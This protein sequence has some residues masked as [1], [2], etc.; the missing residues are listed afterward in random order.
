MLSHF[1]RFTVLLLFLFAGSVTQAQR[2]VVSVEMGVSKTKEISGAWRY[3]QNNRHKP[4]SIL[5]ASGARHIASVYYPSIGVY[6]D[7]DTLAIE[8]KC[9]LLKMCGIDAISFCLP[10]NAIDDP[11]FIHKQKAHFRYMERYGLKAFPRYQAIDTAQMS[12][13]MDLFNTPQQ[14]YLDKRPLFSFFNADMDMNL[15]EDWRRSRAA[16]GGVFLMRRLYTD[17]IRLTPNFDGVYDWVGDGKGKKY[18]STIYPYIWHYNARQIKYAYRYDIRKARSLQDAGLVHY[19]A[20]G[21][22]PGFDDIPVN[23]WGHGPRYIERDNGRV[24]AY[25]WKRAVRNGFPMVVIPTWDDWGEGTTIAPTVEYGD[26]YLKITRKYAAAYKGVKEPEGD[27]MLPVWIYRLRKSSHNR[28]LVAATDSASSLIVQGQFRQAAQ[29]IQPWL[30]VFPVMSVRYWDRAISLSEY[31]LKP[32]VEEGRTAAATFTIRKT[33]NG[34]LRYTIAAN[35][36]WLTVSKP[37]GV[38]H[39]GGEALVQVRCGSAGLKKGIHEGLLTVS[40]PGSC[41]KTQTIK[42]QLEVK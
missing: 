11:W 12:W 20:E 40:D 39:T 26:Q 8:Y 42:V 4:D 29:L 13:I 6:D 33:G 34:D 27:L 16:S 3:W 36:D 37:S 19:Y 21:V 1:Y 15:L 9:Q 18:D 17:S 31:E 41:N 25:K 5:P 24:Y 14:V 22:S 28:Q 10:A 32:S 35:V 30:S 7:G 23:G 38:V 2:M